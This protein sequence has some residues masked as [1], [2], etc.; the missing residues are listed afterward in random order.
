[1]N[2]A[3]IPKTPWLNLAV[4]T[5]LTG[6]L[7][8]LGGMA[9]AMLLHFLQ[10]L[11]FGYSQNQIISDESFLIGVTQASPS[12]RFWVLLLCGLVAGGGWWLL[13]RFAKPLVSISNAVKSAKPQMPIVA[14]TL[15]ALLQI[16]TIALG[17]PLGREVAPREIGA[18]LANWLSQR[19]GLSVRET[20]IM[21]ACG[22]GAGLAAVY[23]VPLS[24][25][26]FVLEV[27]LCS[28]SWPLLIP[29][30]A[31]S[32]IAALVAWLGLGNEV[33]YHLPDLAVTPGLMVWAAL[34]G[35]L[36]G[37]CAYYFTR[38]TNQAK[39]ASPRNGWLPLL[40]V[41]NFALIGVLAGFFPQLLG[42]GKGP[43]QISFDDTLTL[44]LAL[45]LLLLKL[46]IIWGSLRA[47]AQ[48]GL[49]TPGL[50][51]GALLAY[52]IGGVWVHFLPGT[53]LGAFAVVGG[54]AFLAASMRMPITAVLLVFELTRVN[55]DFL[56]PVIFAVVG[57]I[58][59]LK[60][61]SQWR[62]KTAS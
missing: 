11:M 25:A 59:T 39:A 29:A 7:A 13:Y 43:A 61:Y 55:H 21:I 38:I 40:C 26:I 1:M 23:N 42:N 48:G 6:I 14:T 18:M 46:L 4:A 19:L 37:F 5:L 2:E 54:C 44:Q 52:L 15:H 30:L 36:F 57:S 60:L 33:Q 16:V 10:H 28:F 47:G 50:M 45:V 12:R 9:V 32:S 49:L 53:E 41:L 51:V 34:M 62:E 58:T 20:Q 56:I 17:S 8:G 24:G 35:P 22:A 27:L 31:T 3:A